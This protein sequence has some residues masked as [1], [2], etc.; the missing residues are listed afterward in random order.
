[1]APDTVV[2]RWHLIVGLGNPGAEYGGTR[3]NVGFMVVDRLGECWKAR[4]ENSRR[5][6]ARVA[7]AQVGNRRVLLG[8]PQ[9]YMNLSGSAVGALVEF[10]RVEAARVLVVVDDADLPLGAVRMR[11]GGGSGGHHGLESIES[12]LGTRDYVRLRVGIGRSDGRREITGHVLGR[13]AEAERK[14]LEQVLVRAADQA[15][16]WLADGVAAAM[17]RYNGV[18]ENQIN[19]ASA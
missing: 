9:T 6:E 11:P 1:V 18:V 15:A 17:N 3:H 19:D 16:C 10:Y 7:R 8:Q 14:V 5:F 12:R 4:W 2:E 13:F